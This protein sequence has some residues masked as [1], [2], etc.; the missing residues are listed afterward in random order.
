MEP[1]PQCLWRRK[2][3]TCPSWRYAMFWATVFGGMGLGATDGK[4]AQERPG[5]VWVHLSRE[6][7][8]LQDRMTRV[9]HWKPTFLRLTFRPKMRAGDGWVDNRTRSART[10]RAGCRELDLPTMAEK[11]RWTYLENN[12]ATVAVSSLVFPDLY[13]FLHPCQS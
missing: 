5:K 8:A 1:K 6:K 7:C 2:L 11:K 10:V 3:R 12:F 4:D 13:P 9:R